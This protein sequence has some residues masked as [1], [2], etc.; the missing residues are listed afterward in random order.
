VVVAGVAVGVGVGFGLAG[1]ATAVV[2]VADGALTGG[3]AAHVAANAPR[4]ETATSDLIPT[5]CMRRA[6]RGVV[7]VR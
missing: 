3:G 2:G 4:N 6:T 7:A 1:A 5:W